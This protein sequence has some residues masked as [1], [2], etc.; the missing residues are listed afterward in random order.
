[1]A[2]A[3]KPLFVV[4]GLPRLMEAVNRVALGF[5]GLLQLHFFSCFTPATVW[6]KIVGNKIHKASFE[7]PTLALCQ[8]WFRADISVSSAK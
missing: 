2:Y 5:G 8:L 1:M 7:T 3:V 4:D 6:V